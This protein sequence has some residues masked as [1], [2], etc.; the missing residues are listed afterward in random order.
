[1]PADNRPEFRI[2]HQK[3]LGFE[4]QLPRPIDPEPTKEVIR[5]RS[6]SQRRRFEK[7]RSD[8]EELIFNKGT[9]DEY[10]RLGRYYEIDQGTD[11]LGVFDIPPRTGRANRLG[12]LLSGD[13]IFVFKDSEKAD[14]SRRKGWAE[15]VVFR[16]AN[17]TEEPNMQVF[18]DGFINRWIVRVNYQGIIDRQVLS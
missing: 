10:R 6:I 9:K 8:W 1:M 18:N 7:G 15:V 2:P 3:T 14:D 12:S 4:K 16:R 11:P 5:K 17:S 13:K